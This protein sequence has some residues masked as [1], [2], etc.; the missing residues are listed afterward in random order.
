M[1]CGTP[2]LSRSRLSRAACALYRDGG[3]DLCRIIALQAPVHLAGPCT[4]LARHPRL[5]PVVAPALKPRTRCPNLN[6]I[7]TAEEEVPHS[8]L[9]DRKSTRLNSSHLGI[10]YA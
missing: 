2:P 6:R 4:C 5:L 9:E 7:P 3:L 1:A 10:S 8:C